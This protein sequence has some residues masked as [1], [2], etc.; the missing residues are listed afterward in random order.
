V[1]PQIIDAR[2]GVQIGS[3]LWGWF[4]GWSADGQFLATVA[5]GSDCGP[6]MLVYRAS[7][8]QYLHCARG[9]READFHPDGSALAYL[10]TTSEVPALSSRDAALA[11]N[12][13]YLMNLSDG[14]EHLL[15]S[16]VRGYLCAFWSPDGRWLLVS[17]CGGL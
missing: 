3:P 6:A 4:H 13:V 15:L 12:D 16:G 2:T 8:A 17:M 11:L 7:D 10:R 5:G 1:L 14:S 9:T